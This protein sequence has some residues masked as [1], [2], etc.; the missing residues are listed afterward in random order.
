MK[1][2]FENT[3]GSTNDPCGESAP[4][5][6]LCWTA[7]QLLEHSKSWPEHAFSSGLIEALAKDD[8]KQLKAIL[9]Q[10]D[11][12]HESIVF[13][14]GI[15]PES[16]TLPFLGYAANMKAWN[17]ITQAIEMATGDKAKQFATDTMRLA[18]RE[19]EALPDTNSPEALEYRN[20]IQAMYR[21]RLTKD[22]CTDGSMLLPNSLISW[23]MLGQTMSKVFIDL[24]VSKKVQNPL[25]AARVKGFQRL[26]LAATNDDAQAIEKAIEG[27][28]ANWTA[29]LQALPHLKGKELFNAYEAERLACHLLACG[30]HE[31]FAAMLAKFAKHMKDPYKLLPCLLGVADVLFSEWEDTGRERDSRFV[32]AM[33]PHVCRLLT[34]TD[35]G[36][37]EDEVIHPK[38]ADTRKFIADCKNANLAASERKSIGDAITTGSDMLAVPGMDAMAAN[39]NAAMPVRAAARGPRRL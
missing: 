10:C 7:Y 35:Y 3:N 25:I 19:L 8:V 2:V 20:A 1:Q 24:D 17:C 26:W 9:S 11:H 39:D 14:N 38:K 27:L 21:G 18:I 29:V 22:V 4:K 34:V 37:N 12:D 31:A 13:D 16:L 15:E 36:K 30:G 28:Y 6:A 23:P 5:E 33:K 32:D